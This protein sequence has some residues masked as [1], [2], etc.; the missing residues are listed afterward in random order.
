MLDVSTINFYLFLNAVAVRSN[1]QTFSCSYFSS[2]SIHSVQLGLDCSVLFGS[3]ANMSFNFVR[4][5]RCR[6][7]VFVAFLWA[8]KLNKS[9]LVKEFSTY[10]L[11]CASA[12]LLTSCKQKMDGTA[13]L[14]QYRTNKWQNSKRKIICTQPK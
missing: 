4:L 13:Q 14:A 11:L 6:T 12:L 3:G 8:I 5:L 10:F 1:A 9:I 2:I 7:I